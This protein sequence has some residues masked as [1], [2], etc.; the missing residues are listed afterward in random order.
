MKKLCEKLSKNYA[1]VE[2]LSS[3]NSSLYANIVI[4]V[5][6]SA[7]KLSETICAY[8]VLMHIMFELKLTSCKRKQK[9]NKIADE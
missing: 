2:L 5:N 4:G 8:R 9:F 7:L 3:L 6:D 1:W